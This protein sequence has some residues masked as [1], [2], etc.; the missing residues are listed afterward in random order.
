MTV[1][2]EDENPFVFLEYSPPAAMLFDWDNT[3]VETW[4]T[5]FYAIN[6]TLVAF[7]LEAWEEDF[8]LSNIQHSGREAFP[9]LF[10]DKAKE[11]QKFFYKV[12][13]EDHLQGLKP[14]PEA[15]A[16]LQVLKEM[17]IP[18]GV[19]SNKNSIFLRKE[20]SH[21]GWE[22]Y[23]KVLVGA[24]D[25]LRDKPAA[26]PIL[27]ALETLKVPA[28]TEVWMVGDAPVDWDCAKAAGC[29]AIAIGNRFE[30][31]PSVFVSIENCWELKK[32]FVKM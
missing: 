27:L 10:G 20:V 30:P 13:E 29:Q 21:L 28:S 7:G 32:I 9:K 26:D 24:G 22:T 19:V 6:K 3:L 14:M 11:A 8:A 12:V 31:S 18:L 16:L 2:H 23:F 17:G 1:K 25:A 5:I 15:E 4:K